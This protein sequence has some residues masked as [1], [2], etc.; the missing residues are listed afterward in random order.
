MD[1][2]QGAEGDKGSTGEETSEK[3][4]EGKT[5]KEGEG[6]KGPAE[7]TFTQDELNSIVASEKRKQE[8]KTQK[9]KDAG[10]S[11]EDISALEKREEAKSSGEELE[12]IRQERVSLELDK[13]KELV[14]KLKPEQV[15][16]LKT[17][18][19]EQVQEFLSGWQSLLSPA[20]AE[21]KGG[22][23]LGSVSEDSAGEGEELSEDLQKY[24]EGIEEARGGDPSKLVGKW[25]KDLD[26]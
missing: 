1:K 4:P 11:D 23:E 9:Y 21:E 15:E 13:N 26:I 12:A 8:E 3:K 19:V 16:K 7:K 14:E 17:A 18:S 20:K 24:A 10:L 6:N 22:G 5:P 25:I 2:L